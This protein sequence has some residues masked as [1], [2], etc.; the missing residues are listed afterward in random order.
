MSIRTIASGASAW[1][2][3]QCY[4]ENKVLSLSQTGY[5]E[6]TGLVAG[7]G[8]DPYQVTI[9]TE[10]PRRSK[11]NCPHA[12]GRRVVC[13]HMVALY[14]AAFPDEAKQYMKEVKE[15]EREEEKRQKEHLAE[16]R[17]YVKSLSKRELQDELFESLLKLDEIYRSRW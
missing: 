4:K 2:G 17:A 9:N 16:I 12:D 8:A 11:C 15:A 14:F 3:Y 13:K 1:R 7:S 6:Y 10:H 5:D